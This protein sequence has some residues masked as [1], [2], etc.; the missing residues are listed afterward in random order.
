MSLHDVYARTTPFELA[1]PGDAEVTALASAVAEEAGA[2]GVDARALIDFLTLGS[3][4]AFIRS[5]AG[6]ETDP[7]TLHRFGPVVYHALRFEEA[8]RHL[9]L[10]TTHAARYLVEGA[11]DGDPGPPAEA[12]YIQLPQ[13][14]FWTRAAADAPESIDGV[15]WSVAP[16]GRLHVLLVTGLRPDR[17]GVG[18]VPLPEAPVDDAASWLD[19]DAREEGPDYSTDLPGAD[20]DGLCE[21]R[22]PGEVYKLLARFFAHVS[23]NPEAVEEGSPTSPPVDSSP[24]PSRLDYARV[25][26]G[27][28]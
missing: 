16:G 19:L 25:T 7:G 9:H 8:G 11:P 24:R 21:I 2:R 4:E 13:H 5:T 12:G 26:L 15:F 18:V 27:M 6:G 22:S 23:G 17:P 20:I 28:P 1:F 10:L 14:L 3:V